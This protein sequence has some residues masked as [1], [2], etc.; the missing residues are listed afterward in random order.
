MVE[1]NKISV[2]VILHYNEKSIIDTFECV[3]SIRKICINKKY[4]IVLVENGSKDNS[5]KLL[6]KKFKND[7]D[8]DLIISKENLGFARGNNLGCEYAI[9]K[10]LV[11]YLIV[12][13]N[14]TYIRQKE[15]LDLINS[16][17]EKSNFHILG[18]Y[19]YDRKLNP[20][21]P[22]L[23]L[24][25]KIREVE[26]SILSLKKQLNRGRVINK[27]ISISKN[28]IFSNKKLEVLIRKILK[29]PRL[30]LD[31]YAESRLENIG[32]HGSCLI[33]SRLYI[34]KYR[35]IFYPGTFMFLEEDILYNRVIRDNL[36]SVYNPEI[37]IYHKEDKSTEGLLGKNEEKKRFII[38]NSIKSLE[39]YRNILIKGKEEY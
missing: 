36:K 38:I 8:I 24:K 20:Q 18:P 13:N 39:I 22:N 11:E 9:K 16:E 30:D 32:L 1:I 19:I 4:K 34:E 31:N 37:R 7:K 28:V 14:D 12:L 10:Y 6:I 3:D 2:F 35:N 23:N 17:Y 15:F 21:N 26:L 5:E 25:T 27:L 29:K 33:F